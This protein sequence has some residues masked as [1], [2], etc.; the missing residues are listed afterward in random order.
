MNA[1]IGMPV[2]RLMAAARRRDGVTFPALILVIIER[3][4]F[5]L[6]AKVASVVSVDERCSA[7][8]VMARNV[9]VMNVHVKHNV[10]DITWTAKS[11]DARM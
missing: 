7:S 1:S 11:H 5:T 6:A 2:S 8:R 9:N 10:N 3:S 4:Q